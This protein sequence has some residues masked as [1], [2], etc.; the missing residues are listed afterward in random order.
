MLLEKREPPERLV[1][2]E[3]LVKPVLQVKQVPLEQ[4]VKQEPQGR[5]E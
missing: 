2:R 4:R 3:Q 1:L 5:R